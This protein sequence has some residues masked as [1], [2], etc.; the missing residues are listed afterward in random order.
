MAEDPA[1]INGI[2]ILLFIG[3][4]FAPLLAKPEDPSCPSTPAL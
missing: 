2:S 3:L 1:A 4:A